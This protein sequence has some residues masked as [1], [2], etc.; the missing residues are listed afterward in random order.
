LVIETV[1]HASPIQG[2]TEICAQDAGTHGKHWIYAAYNIAIAGVFLAKPYTSD[3]ICA[4]RMNNG[5]VT[6]TERFEGAF[7]LCFGNKQGSIYA[8]PLSAFEQGITDF[9]EEVVTKK[10]VEPLRE[11]VID[12]VKQYMLDLQKDGQLTIYYYPDR[13]QD[14]PQDDEDLIVDAVVWHRAYGDAA[15][16]KLAQYHPHLKERAALAIQ[17]DTYAD[18]ECVN[19]I[20][21][22]KA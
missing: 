8:L 3:F 20:S 5:T 14:I 4:R 12:D 1:Y 17:N 6:L 15:L 7:D 16:D 11:T 9:C 2:L 10:T 18:V 13:A 21:A 22:F 19:L